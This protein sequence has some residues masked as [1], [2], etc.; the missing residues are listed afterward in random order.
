MG[1]GGGG[2]GGYFL[3]IAINALPCYKMGTVIKC[4]VFIFYLLSSMSFCVKRCLSGLEI[5][6][7]I[8]G[9]WEEGTKKNLTDFAQ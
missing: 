3:S 7:D 1:G 2:G 5:A 9:V 4:I 6:N 8:N